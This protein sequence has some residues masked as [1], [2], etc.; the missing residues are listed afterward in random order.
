MATTQTDVPINLSDDAARAGVTGHHVRYVLAYGLGG[1][2]AAFAG[3]GIYFGFDRLVEGFNRA[4]S[5]NPV[6]VIQNAVPYVL[7]IAAGAIAAVLLLGLWNKL[8]GKDDDATQTGM[9]MRVVLQFAVIC[10]I[11]VMLYLFTA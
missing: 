7:T 1:I 6:E 11:M 9:R 3:I 8:A 5:R 4:L 2:V 10:V